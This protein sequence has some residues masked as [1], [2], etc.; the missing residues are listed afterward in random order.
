MCPV[1]Q[2][3]TALIGCGKVG[4]TH[5]LAFSNLPQSKFVAV[6][7]VDPGRAEAFAAR[8]HVQAYTDPEAM[9]ARTDVQMVSVC[10]PHP[11]H[12]HYAVMAAQA[13]VHTLVEKPLAPNLREAD[14]T[15]LAHK[16]AGTKLGMVSQRRFY[17]ATQRVWRAIQEGRIGKP[18]LAIAQV[19]SWR[20][21]GYYRMDPWR[22]KWDLEGGGV[23]V[24]QTPH[25][26]DILQWL[27][28]PIDELYGQWD[29]FTHPYIEVEDSAAAIIRFRS[30]AIGVLLLSNSQNPG[31]YG[32]IRVHGT[33]GATI[34]V[35]T[36]GGSVF[37]S[38]VTAKVDPPMNH[39]W[40]IPGEEHLLARWQQEDRDLAERVNIMTYFHERQIEDFLQAIIE[41]REPLVTGEQG[42]V[43]VEMFTAIYRSQRDGKPIKFPVPAE[44]GQADYD[45]RLSK[46]LYSRTR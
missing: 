39:I 2:V 38:G 14:Q 26:L 33:S 18:I 31:L 5:A 4:E 25:H 44:D 35:E 13:G 24:N 11:T 27:M 8:F 1:D 15:I 40:T 12:A 21:E 9:L 32:R 29:N 42:R 16:A 37:V 28:G 43:T 45:G 6:Y 3:G 7:D 30:G 46:A 17:P 22:G 34:G 20:G 19:L 23:L 10:T 41:D 36:D